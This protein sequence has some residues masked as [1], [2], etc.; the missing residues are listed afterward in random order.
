VRD[1]IVNGT[2]VLSNGEHTGAKP[3]RA[4]WGIGR[5]Q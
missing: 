2:Q 4:L 5:R 3:G 1:V